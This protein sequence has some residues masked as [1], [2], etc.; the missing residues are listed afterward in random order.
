M[1]QASTHVKEQHGEERMS[2]NPGLPQWIFQPRWTS[3]GGGG[4]TKASNRAQESQES[5]LKGST[6]SYKKCVNRRKRK[7]GQRKWKGERTGDRNAIFVFL[8]GGGRGMEGRVWLVCILYLL[9]IRWHHLSRGLMTAPDHVILPCDSAIFW[10]N[11]WPFMFYILAP[12]P[13]AKS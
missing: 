9:P 7:N 1:N 5:R 13:E 4:A 3:T 8:W 2:N 12:S 10:R 11:C 6:Q